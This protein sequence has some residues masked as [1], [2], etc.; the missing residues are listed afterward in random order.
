MERKVLFG[1]FKYVAVQNADTKY[2]SQFQFTTLDTLNTLDTS[3]H[4]ICCFTFIYFIFS[5]NFL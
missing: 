1:V 2:I 5:R 4:Q 3:I